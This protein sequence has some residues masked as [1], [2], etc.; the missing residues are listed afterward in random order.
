VP[1]PLQ[2]AGVEGVEQVP[3]VLLGVRGRVAVGA[4]SENVAYVCRR[5]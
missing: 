3:L 5:S 4:A 1:I 2:V